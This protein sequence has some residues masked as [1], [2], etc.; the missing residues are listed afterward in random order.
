MAK[1]VEGIAAEAAKV[2]EG[3]RVRL[4]KLGSDDVF[5]IFFGNWMVFV[6]FCIH[7]CFCLCYLGVMFFLCVFL[8]LC[9][10]YICFSVFFGGQGI[11]TFGFIINTLFCGIII[12][13]FFFLGGGVPCLE[14]VCLLVFEGFDFV[15]LVGNNTIVYV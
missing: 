6:C 9:L 5:N 8:L 1:D 10:W 14:F 12:I 3:L 7:V 4:G 2:E 11:S 13:F 15:V